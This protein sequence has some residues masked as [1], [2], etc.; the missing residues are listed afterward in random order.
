MYGIVEEFTEDSKHTWD[1]SGLVLLQFK[2][3][4]KIM[5]I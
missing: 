1:T 2:K 3:K 4:T 5:L